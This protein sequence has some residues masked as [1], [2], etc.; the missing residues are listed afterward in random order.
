MQ[1]GFTTFLKLGFE[2][3]SDINAIDHMLFIIVLCGL[4]SFKDWKKVAILATAFTIGHSITLALAAYEIILFPKAIIEFLIPVTIFITAIYNITQLSNL[5]AKTES[6]SN[7]VKTNY[8]FA[9]FFG[10]IHGMGFSNF[11]KSL[12]G[13]KSS[14]VQPLLSFNIGIELGQLLIVFFLMILSFF[15]LRKWNGKQ[16]DWTL[17]ISAMGCGIAFLMMIETKFW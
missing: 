16:R 7:R 13:G 4:Y 17:F 10:L 8:I 9:L 1:S 2:H 3:I 11:F 15:F 5:E 6:S 14:I 12:L